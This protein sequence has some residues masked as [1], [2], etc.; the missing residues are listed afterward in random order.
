MVNIT[1]ILQKACKQLTEYFAGSRTFFDL[2]LAPDG[3][4][5]QQKVWQE[6]R[7]I[8][9]GETVSYGEIA[10]RIGNPKACRAVGGAN[11]KNPILIMIPCHRCIGVSGAMV[12]FGCGIKVKEQLL[13]LE[14]QN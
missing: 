2:P 4:A 12:G 14:K 1:L 7:K 10:R 13:D 8:P 3:T 5:F 9:Y 11:N 6:L